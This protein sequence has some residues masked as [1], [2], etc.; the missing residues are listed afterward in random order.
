MLSCR[1]KDAGKPQC[2]LGSLGCREVQLLGTSLDNIHNNR[3]GQGYA[4]VRFTPGEF[5]V[6]FVADSPGQDEDLCGVPFQGKA[7]E[8]FEHFVTAADIDFSKVYVTYVTKCKPPYNRK[9][10]VSEINTCKDHV[11]DELLVIKPKVVVLLGEMAMRV[12]N[13]TGKGGLKNIHGTIWTVPIPFLED[14]PIF[15]VVPMYHPASVMYNTSQQFKQSVQLDYGRIADVLNYGLDKETTE[16]FKTPYKLI[17]TLE[18]TEWLANVLSK[19]D[20]FAFDTESDGLP[21]SR[22]PMLCTSFA[23]EGEED[24][25]TA[26]VLPYYWHDATMEGAF[27]GEWH[28]PEIP[29]SKV[30]L[31][32]K[33]V[34]EN[35]DIAKIAHNIKYDINVMRWHTGI[36]IKGVLYD[37][38]LMHHLLNESPPHDLEHLADI[39]FRIGDYSADKRAITGQGKVLRAGYSNVPNSILWQYT[40]N[41][42]QSCL[43]LFGTFLPRLVKQKLLELYLSECVPLSYALAEAEWYGN[44]I[45]KKEAI[46]IKTKLEK[47]QNVLFATMREQSG[48]QEF[49][50]NSHPQ[51]AAVLQKSGYADAIKDLKKAS[52]YTVDKNIL[53]TIANTLPFAAN[54]LES[55]ANAKILTTYVDRAMKD[56]DEDG[57]LRYSW[58][59]HGTKTGRLSCSFLHQ[60]PKTGKTNVRSLF[61]SDKGYD[62]VYLDYSQIELR[63]MA[64]CA[65]DQV[66]LDL[67]KNNID[68]HKATASSA[69]GIPLEAVSDLNRGVGKAI[70]F[71]LIFG[72]QG[73]QLV[74]KLQYET[75]DGKKKKLDFET[76][77]L[78]LERTRKTFFNITAFCEDIPLQAMSNGGMLRTVFGRCRRLGTMLNAPQKG[79]REH[80]ERE[81]VN[82]M[83][84]STASAITVRTIIEVHDY[85]QSL[86]EAGKI[87][88]GDVKLICTVHDSI[89]YEVKKPLTQWFQGVLRTIAERPIEELDN[90]KFPV[91]IGVGNSWSAAEENSKEN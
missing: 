77:S 73:F 66:M 78:F 25:V 9:P 50:P 17:H 70:N 20:V 68:I 87:Q 24:G 86:I 58:L 46:N 79:I 28:W 48:D 81:A 5:D 7:G 83:I 59:I 23:W 14:S 13:L 84:Q 18:D 12:F 45:D 80:A 10:S 37:T 33:K 44:K 3:I 47:R 22:S 85:L 54:V 69:L 15:T 16:S 36:E 74:E 88:R 35:P 29:Y 76:I 21:W 6:V 89:A 31:P 72:S 1:I 43:N 53:T 64:I 62:Y 19:K 52:N 49:N 67:F 4:P 34:F 91:N 32:L 2:A 57:R 26:A 61:I 42:S 90:S 65:K 30:V 55:R 41:D 51:V 56:L 39:E 82:F 75:L 60:I 40:A 11:I 27:K 38:M 63:V 71:G 8:L